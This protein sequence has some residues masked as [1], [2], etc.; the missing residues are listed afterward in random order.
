ML[1]IFRGRLP[2]P[3]RSHQEH[4]VRGELWPEGRALGPGAGGRGR[5]CVPQRDPAGGPADRPCPTG[6][7]SGL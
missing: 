3:A 7:T 6:Q 4:Q 2:V 5:L 1:C